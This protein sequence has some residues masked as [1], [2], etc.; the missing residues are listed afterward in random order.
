PTTHSRRSRSGGPAMNGM[1]MSVGASDLGGC[2]RQ[3]SW[4]D[5]HFY[6]EGLRFMELK[7]FGLSRTILARGLSRSRADVELRCERDRKSCPSVGNF[8]FSD[9]R[10][11]ATR[12]NFPLDQQGK[13]AGE[14]GRDDL[15]LRGGGQ[16]TSTM[17]E[18]SRHSFSRSNNLRAHCS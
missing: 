15:S 3:A 5:R 16:R 18:S 2:Q 17:I 10:L 4:V 6:S 13:E 1:P 12:V 9:I 7:T 14:T 8:L 11:V